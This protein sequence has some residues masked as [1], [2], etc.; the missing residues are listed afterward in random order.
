MLINHPLDCPICDKAGECDL[1]T[2]PTSTGQGLSRFEEDKQIKH[3]KDLGPNI[4]IWGN[5][6]IVCTRCVRFCEEVTGTGELC[7]IERGDRSVVDVFPGIPIDN[8]LSLNV[9]DL[10]PVGRPHRQ[11]LH[12]RGA[13]LV[14][15]AGRERLRARAAAAATST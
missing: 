3:T 1:R 12:V 11:E 9:V 6:C 7:V 8:P 10:C 5:R 13:R 2:T 14:H 4:R 15:R